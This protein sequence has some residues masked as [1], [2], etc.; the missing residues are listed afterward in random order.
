MTDDRTANDAAAL[1]QATDRVIR[2]MTHVEL[3]EDA[4]T[5][6]MARIRTSR[7]GAEAMAGAGGGLLGTLLAP[8]VS[9]GLAVA[10]AA[11]AAIVAAGVT[12]VAV[13]GEHGFASKV[14]TNATPPNPVAPVIT[15]VK[16]ASRASA[17]GGSG[18]PS[19]GQPAG[20]GQTVG[21]AMVM[22]PDE[23]PPHAAQRVPPL[24]DGA[25]P[26]DVKLEVTITDQSGAT[27]PIAKTVSLVV[28]DREG[29]SVESETRVPFPQRPVKAATPQPTVAPGWD[30]HDLPLNVHVWP[31]IMAD[32]HVRVR[33]M[34]NYRT[35][36]GAPSAPDA[37]M[38]TAMVKKELTAVLSDGKP[39]VIST[40]ADAATDRKVTVELK[41]SIQK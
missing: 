2:E 13:R 31:V 16:H 28:A 25:V 8:R 29:G 20:A 19:A 5:R 15:P 4:V 41:A 38:A 39:L 40:S 37:P 14:A 35:A 7:S 34:L 1:D 36:G 10:T 6:V 21:A 33:L 3:S 27:K 30:W 23:D 12:L 22:Q 11:L 17:G 26:Q 32:G 18:Q 9:W 24:P